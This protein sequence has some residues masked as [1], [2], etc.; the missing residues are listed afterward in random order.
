GDAIALPLVGMLSDRFGIDRA[1]MLLPI[2]SIMG[3]IVV[4][5]AM[6]YVGRDMRRAGLPTAEYQAVI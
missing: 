4:L 1:I 5:V 3:G 6:R 2:V